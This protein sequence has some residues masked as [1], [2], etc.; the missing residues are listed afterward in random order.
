MTVTVATQEKTETAPN[1]FSGL[2]SV[3]IGIVLTV[4]AFVTLVLEV[5]FLPIYAGHAHMASDTGSTLARAAAPLASSIT[6]G[7]I[8]VPVT[9]L[10]AAVINV[11]LVLGMATVSHRVPVV[12]IPLAVWLLGFLLCASTGPGGSV[13]LMSDWPTMLL[14]ICGLLPAGLYLYYRATMRLAAGGK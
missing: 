9:A 6:S 1:P 4:D 7:A 2:L 8:P 10:A 3:V 11:L 13:V 14:L 12:I 5:L